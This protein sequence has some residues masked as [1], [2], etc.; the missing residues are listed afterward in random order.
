MIESTAVEITER[1]DSFLD[2]LERQ[3]T[4]CATKYAFNESSEWT[5]VITMKVPYWVEGT[6]LKYLGRLKVYGRERDLIKVAT[7]C[8]ILWIKYGLHSDLKPCLG[9]DTYCTTVEQK[10]KFWPE[11]RDLV[12]KRLLTL[13]KNSLGADTWTDADMYRM[14]SD[15]TLLAKLVSNMFETIKLA[16]S[17]LDAKTRSLIL[18]DSAALCLLSWVQ[19]GFH[20]KTKHDEDLGADKVDVEVQLPTMTTEDRNALVSDSKGE[21]IV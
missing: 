1:S 2:V 16:R 4:G 21:I 14:F 6:I 7:Y 17:G 10:A 5:D 18:V 12:G 20:T 9:T 11:F 15:D 19:D 8:F 3:F 13:S